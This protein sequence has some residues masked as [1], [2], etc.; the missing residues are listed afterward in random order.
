M[1][2]Y[3]KENINLP[4]CLVA[5]TILLVAKVRVSLLRIPLERDEG[6]FAYIGKH[7]FSEKLYTDLH[8]NKLPGLY[9]LYALFIKLF[10]YSP[11]GIH[12]G[13]LLCNSVAIWLTFKLLSGL[14]DKW[15]G[16]IAAIVFALISLSVNVNGFAAHANQLLMPFALGGLILLHKALL[17]KRLICFA[18][19][20]LLLGLAFTIKQQVVSYGV[21]AG[22][23]I[24]WDRVQARTAIRQTITEM[25]AFSAGSVVPFAVICAYFLSV[26]RF[27]DFRMW[28]VEL[29]AQLSTAPNLGYRFTLF[30]FYFSKVTRFME[31]V[32]IMAAAGWVILPFLKYRREAR[33]FGILFP[34]FSA[35]SVL[36][37]VAYYPHYFVLCLPAVGLLTGILIVALQQIIRGTSGK[38]F[39]AA[40]LAIVLLFPVVNNLGY[41]YIPVFHEIHRDTYGDNRF[42]EMQ[43]I[44]RKLKEETLFGE[45]I[46]IL[47]SEPEI[48]V[49]ANR[50]AAS[51]HLFMYNLFSQGPKSELLQQQ[52]LDDLKKSDPRFIVWAKAIDSWGS[53][54]Q[55]TAFFKEIRTFVDS[56]YTIYEGYG[57]PPTAD[58][59]IVIFKKRE[60]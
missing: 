56:G 55:A 6:G 27:G 60:Q 41:Y 58:Q 39:A 28:T 17:N 12:T 20:G 52:F 40:T 31:P 29:P 2:K 24:F 47:G 16:A 50:E 44:G 57:G 59:P 23:W 14:F 21:F 45:R 53:N 15:T 38:I 54:Y 8:D 19:A 51:G 42:P 46:G 32:W 5:A 36:I 33:S 22:V 7:L 9:G 3:P 30:Q 37:G 25:A 4:F 26:H 35:M 48:L 34:L 18:G 43:R 1:K 49:V 13:L 11:E 10:G